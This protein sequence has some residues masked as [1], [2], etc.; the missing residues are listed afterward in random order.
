MRKSRA[1]SLG[2]RLERFFAANPD[3][4]LS[5]EDI[6]LKFDV[7]MKTALQAVQKEIRNARSDLESVHVIRR[8][9]KVRA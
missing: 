2:G 7:P 5:Y 6:V 3:E 9:S 4:E 8:R 1:E